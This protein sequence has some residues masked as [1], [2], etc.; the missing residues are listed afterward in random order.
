[1]KPVDIRYFDS[2]AHF[3]SWLEQHHGSAGPTWVAIA[4]SGCTHHVLTYQEAL[5]SALSFGWIDGVVG[6]IDAEHYAQRFSQRRPK[7]NWSVVNVRRIEQLFVAGEVHVSGRA[8]FESRDAAVSEDAVATLG[9][10]EQAAFEEN[11][12]AWAFFCKQ[13]PGYRRQASWYVMSART[14]ATRLRRLNRVISAS[15]SGQRLP[16]Y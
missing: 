9:T 16:G 12:D 8:A 1:M 14:A 15:A 4:K 6:R 3:R 7:S 5:D 10:D 11:T 13:P 2:A